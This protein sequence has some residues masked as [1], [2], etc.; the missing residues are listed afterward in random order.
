MSLFQRAHDVLAAKANK[1]LDAAERQGIIPSAR[2][3]LSFTVAPPPSQPS[4]G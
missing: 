2:Q 4:Q 3:V 1:A